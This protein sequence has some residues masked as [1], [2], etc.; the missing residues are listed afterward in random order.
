MFTTLNWH[1]VFAIFSSCLSSTASI[2]RNN[3]DLGLRQQAE[4]SW[5]EAKSFHSA[6]RRRPPQKL[7]FGGHGGHGADAVRVKSPQIRPQ[8]KPHWVC[9]TLSQS[10]SCEANALS[11]WKFHQFK[12][13]NAEGPRGPDGPILGTHGLSWLAWR[14][15]IQW[16]WRFRMWPLFSLHFLSE[17]FVALNCV[18]F[19]WNPNYARNW[20]GIYLYISFPICII[21]DFAFFFFCFCLLDVFNDII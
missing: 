7:R 12:D 15:P 5:S 1:I 20:I 11:P 13:K 2:F 4:T 17:Y 9:S 18:L 8:K 16:R 10:P 21:L 6:L 3:P 14:V 19:H